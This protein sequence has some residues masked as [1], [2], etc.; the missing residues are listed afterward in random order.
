MLTR[1]PA[2]TARRSRRFGGHRHVEL[3]ARLEDDLRVELGLGTAASDDDPAGAVAEDVGVGIGDGQHHALGH[4]VAGHA[5]L[6]VHAGDDDVE[7]GEQLGLLVEAAVLVDVDLDTG[8]DAERRQLL[9][10][11]ADHLQL[12]AEALGAEPV[13]DGQARRV[14]GEHHVVV[15]EGPRRLGHLADRAAA[16]RP[17]GVGVAVA[18]QCLAQLRTG[19]GDGAALDGLQAAQVDGGLAAL[20]LGDGQ[21]GHLADAGKLLQGARGDAA[22]ELGGVHL[23]HRG[24]GAAEGADAVGRLLGAFQQEGDAAQRGDGG[25]VGGHGGMMPG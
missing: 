12:L 8:E 14:V 19:L 22:V 2:S 13:G 17:V 25:R 1:H 10:E 15:A 11:V 3:P 16:V 23:L 18:A 6:A 21:G 5:Q 7:L 4:L 20:G 24:G 9:V